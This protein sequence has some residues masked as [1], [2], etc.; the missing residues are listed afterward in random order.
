MGET[1]RM[2]I[3][4]LTGMYY[5]QLGWWFRVNGYGI[6]FHDHRKNPPLFSERNRLG[7]RRYHI[8]A[9]CWHFLWPKKHLDRI[10][11]Q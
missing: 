2:K 5:K 11:V 3:G 1:I 4:I 10:A 8:G 7:P 9:W 6:S